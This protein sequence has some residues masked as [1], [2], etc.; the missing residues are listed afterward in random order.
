M[1]AT[2]ESTPTP[3]YHV[4][5]APPPNNG[6]DQGQ[7]RRIFDKRL[8]DDYLAKRHK[9][10]QD[11]ANNDA[12]VSTVS[13]SLWNGASKVER[14][15]IECCEVPD[16]EEDPGRVTLDLKKEVR[17]VTLLA[18]DCHTLS[19]R[20]LALAILE[21]TLVTY[22]NERDSYIH[23]EE[24]GTQSSDTDE[25]D[26]S[27]I[28]EVAVDEHDDDWKPGTSSGM[29]RSP[30][31]HRRSKNRRQGNNIMVKTWTKID[32]T[33]QDQEG[34]GESSDTE[35][36]PDRLD[37]FLAAGGLRILNRW[38][39]EASSS[40]TVGGPKLP[41]GTFQ[42]SSTK[43]PAV[44]IE[45][46]PMRPLALPILGI[47]EH[48]PFNKRLVMESKINKQIKRLGKHV[49]SVLDAHA[50][51]EHQ[52]EDLDGWC[53]ESLGGDESAALDKVHEAVDGLKKTWEAMASKRSVE[54]GDPFQSLKDQMRSR[55]DI[56]MRYEAGEI[57]RP[58]WY[59][60]PET[61]KEPKKRS[62]AADAALAAKKQTTQLLAAKERQS[63]KE[64]LRKRLKAV[65]DESRKRLAA[66]KEQLRKRQ[67][68]MS[69]SY[70]NNKRKS[71]HPLGVG[72]EKRVKWKD[73]HVTKHKR[74]RELL[75]ETFLIPSREDIMADDSN[76]GMNTE[77]VDEQTGFE[78]TASREFMDNDL[79]LL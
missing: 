57:A 16:G 17:F 4:L 72:G 69:A 2:V 20:S 1:S 36:D 63:E 60:E 66:L 43:R 28:E 52:K 37:A 19:S 30:R 65:E 11:P 62:K 68:S 24:Y 27:D 12:P 32:Q 14:D 50:R 44:V 15:L 77:E 31:K 3:P 45:P 55:L 9:A 78:P 7:R 46:S 40:I 74:N 58:D 25:E 64:D 53:V 23:Q 48:M 41:P 26:E 42:N 56:L 5:M 59:E 8:E 73:G 51:G 34:H 75:E 79:S 39:G 67:E 6:S 47:L 21:R 29:R 54:I 71:V 13:C 35:E 33:N 22:L 76:E 49:D 10:Y 18:R 38:L 61:T 70:N